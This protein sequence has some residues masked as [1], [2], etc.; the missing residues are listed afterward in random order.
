[1][2]RDEMIASEG[3][4]VPT[5]LASFNPPLRANGSRPGCVG[6]DGGEDQRAAVIRWRQIALVPEDI[7]SDRKASGAGRIEPRGL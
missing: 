4:P 1:M 7:T 3:P 2:P 5:C 6:R